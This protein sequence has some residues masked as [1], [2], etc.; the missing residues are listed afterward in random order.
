MRLKNIVILVGRVIIHLMR[1]INSFLS[2]YVDSKIKRNK[3]MEDR[4]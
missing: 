2:N 4:R 1:Q 3:I